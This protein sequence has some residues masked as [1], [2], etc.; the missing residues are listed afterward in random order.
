MNSNNEDIGSSFIKLIVMIFVAI[1][2]TI[3]LS[4][5][6]LSE[7]RH[8]PDDNTPV[9]YWLNER[10]GCT[11]EWS[12]ACVQSRCV[13]NSARAIVRSGR[14]YPNEVRDKNGKLVRYD[15]WVGTHLYEMNPED[16]LFQ[17]TGGPKSDPSAY[18]YFSNS[19]GNFLG[20]DEPKFKDPKVGGTLFGMI[21]CTD[22]LDI[23]K[24]TQARTVAATSVG[25]AVEVA[26]NDYSSAFSGAYTVQIQDRKDLGMVEILAKSN[27]FR[28]VLAT[29][30]PYQKPM[31]QLIDGKPYY[32]RIRCDR[33]YDPNADFDSASHCSTIL[34]LDDNYEFS[35]QL[36]QQF[37]PYLP[38]V[39]ERIL[40]ILKSSKRN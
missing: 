31:V 9:S 17:W 24:R 30:V 39:H 16:Y 13:T 11:N 33:R 36:Y 8:Q 10:N 18:H 21:S 12:K 29:Y 1:F 4:L 34:Y 3:L 32:G 7:K 26:K 23:I 19:V 28:E 20:V 25:K 6:S 2:I 38:A 14:P 27:R 5:C 35:V 15:V 40:T 22:N 37:M